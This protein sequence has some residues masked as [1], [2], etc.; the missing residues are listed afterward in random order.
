MQ[1]FKQLRSS[2]AA[3]TGKSVEYTFRIKTIENIAEIQKHPLY[4]PHPD[5]YPVSVHEASHKLY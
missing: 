5:A 4:G 1:R 2:L 3:S